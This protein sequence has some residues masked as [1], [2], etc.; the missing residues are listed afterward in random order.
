MI[1]IRIQQKFIWKFIILYKEI[2]FST[3]L[4]ASILFPIVEVI[5]TKPST[6]I[7]KWICERSTSFNMH[8]SSSYVVVN[9]ILNRANTMLIQA[10]KYDH[11]CIQHCYKNWFMRAH[12]CAQPL[13]HSL[14]TLFQSP[15]SPF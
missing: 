8:I 3:D 11:H 13:S 6:N 10:K 9:E 5:S 4:E 7:I 15:F 2:E 12:K 14:N 1:M